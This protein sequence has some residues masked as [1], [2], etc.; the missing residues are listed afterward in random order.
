[1]INREIYKSALCILAQTTSDMEDH[2]SDYEERAPYL[3]A[4]FCNEVA[5]IDRNMRRALGITEAFSFN[6]AYVS[7][8]D[9]F[10]LLD[11]FVV[12]AARYLAAMLII[13]DDG[14]LSDRLFHMYC[15][16][17]E[18]I[19]NEIPTILESIANKYL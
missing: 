9:D 12:V 8:E 2:V 11:R 15:E 19:R 16:G 13:N 7:L 18:L 14:E 3:I 17:I 10:P 6:K 5:D 1:M 4:C